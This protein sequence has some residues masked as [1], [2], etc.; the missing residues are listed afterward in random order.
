MTAKE[1]DIMVNAMRTKYHKIDSRLD[2]TDKIWYL[3][4]ELYKIGRIEL[5]LEM[6]KL[7]KEIKEIDTDEIVKLGT[8]KS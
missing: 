2:I 4:E 8:F 1:L 7:Y 5:E 3:K 6:Y